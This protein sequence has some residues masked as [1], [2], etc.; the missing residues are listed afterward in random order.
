MKTRISHW[1]RRRLGRIATGA[2]RSRGCVLGLMALFV[3]SSSSARW[4]ARP[5]EGL[6]IEHQPPPCM[7]TEAFPVIEA[8]ASSVQRARSMGR[9][10]LRFRAENDSGWYET[11]F[12]PPT[13]ARF[14]TIL[15]RP[16]PEA[17]RVVYYF[18]AGEPERRSAEFVV[19]V[20]MGGCP[21]ARS[22]PPAEV[23]GIR[24][25]R[26]SSAQAPV[27]EGFATEGVKGDG[28]SS[29]PVWGI[30][31]GTAVGA[32][33]VVLASGRPSA[34]TSPETG[35]S[36]AL[37]ACFTPDPAPEIDSGD[38]LLFD[39][40]CTLPQTVV[41]FHWSFGDGTTAEG[42]SVEHLFRPGGSYTV[43]LT[44]RDGSRTDSLSRIVK[45]RA[46]PTACFVTLPNPPRIR[47]NE[48][49]RLNA[50]CSSG[51]RD[52]GP[53][54]IT[55]YQWDFGDG[56]DGGRG[57][58]VSHLY[59]RPDVFGVTL[60]VTNGDGRRDKTTQFV[61]VDAQAEADT[62]AVTFDSELELPPGG[63]VRLSA[64]DSDT[65][66]LAAPTPQRLRLRARSGENVFDARLVSTSDAPGRW[67]LD[68]RS[69][70]RFV[71]GSL[72]VDAGD[73]LALDAYSVVFRLAEGAPPPIRFRL[74]FER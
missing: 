57:V 33:I 22:L 2:A 17:V 8:Q 49:I 30:L 65:V 43:T 40:S 69:E 47:L 26:T 52:G 58:F 13:G 11:V 61:V 32:S 70:P 4:Q 1:T 10:K 19:S 39:A 53:S 35:G 5:S 14:Q 63:A 66:A 41:S 28:S 67:R 27:P 25:Q 23:E 50:E 59:V 55:S 54:P 9:L 46:T 6:E 64:N 31:G 34:T 15:P 72:R 20:L 12:P 62:G 71:P 68:F 48:S 38:T 42:S 36:A 29:G 16:L 37:R 7:D 56:D 44:V 51:D 60:T 45:V 73:V 74:R 21:G 3:A 24:V 18:A